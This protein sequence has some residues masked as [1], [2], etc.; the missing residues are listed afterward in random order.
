MSE[1]EKKEPEKT[2]PVADQQPAPVA[3]PQSVPVVGPK[4]KVP[5]TVDV[6]VTRELALGER[7]NQIGVV[8]MTL[9]LNA[10]TSEQQGLLLNWTDLVGGVESGLVVRG[11]KA[12]WT[13]EDNARRGMKRHAAIV[14][15]KLPPTLD[16]VW[17]ALKARRDREPLEREF[18]KIAEER[19]R[20]WQETFTAR[21]LGVMHRSV[22]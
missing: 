7:S 10:I 3:D 4:P 16:D 19:Q 12:E 20:R 18:E 6:H 11:T 2:E 15:T 1:D 22:Q 9:D 17:D 21:V 5:I 14:A 8:S 13:S